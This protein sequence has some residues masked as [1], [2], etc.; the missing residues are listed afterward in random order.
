[1]EPEILI[2]CE[3]SREWDWGGS[4]R[5]RNEHLHPSAKVIRAFKSSTEEE[6][7]GESLEVKV[8][9]GVLYIVSS[10]PAGVTWCNL[11]QKVGRG[12]I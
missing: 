12:F 8:Q 1:M 3:G 11:P 2:W 6:E 9:L 7:V 4:M 5:R 10:R